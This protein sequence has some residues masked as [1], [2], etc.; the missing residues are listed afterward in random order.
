M[1]FP[2]GWK[3]VAISIACAFVVSGCRSCEDTGANSDTVD[4]PTSR[5]DVPNDDDGTSDWDG[6]TFDGVRWFV[7]GTPERDV[8]HDVAID[9]KG[10]IYVVGET[11]GDLK[12]NSNGGGTDAFVARLS[13]GGFGFEWVQLIGGENSQ[14]ANS[15]AVGPNDLVY[16]GGRAGRKASSSSVGNSFVAVYDESGTQK[17][18]SSP[19]GTSPNLVDIAVDQQGN[20]YLGAVLTIPPQGSNITTPAGLVVKFDSS[21]SE[22]WRSTIEGPKGVIAHNIAVTANGAYV[23]G[24][25]DGKLNGESEIGNGDVFTVRLN[26]SGKEQWTRLIGS[27]KSELLREAT[28]AAD[29]KGNAAVFGMT[30]G[31]I[32]GETNKG[33]GAIFAVA[34]DSDGNEKWFDFISSG[35]GEYPLDAAA[36]GNGRWLTTGVSG[37]KLGGLTEDNLH[38][39][40]WARYEADGTR[41]T[42]Q[43][44]TPDDDSDDLTLRGIDAA[45]DGTVA[46]VGSTE[47]PIIGQEVSG[48]TDIVV[49]SMN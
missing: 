9:S 42:L 1:Q 6:M 23:V 34:Y 43:A 22:I 24:S 13:D 25:T 48:D 11:E 36:D 26:D 29:S 39:G 4:V 30:L 27:P 38:A 18:I 40:F 20:L 8:A 2:Q 3:F 32:K 7:A 33:R 49:G 37:G 31:S 41:E 35:E 16:V 47:G 10:R 46:F 28:I 19:V 15:V 17:S 5:S 45:P 14:K 12:G 21:N 44:F